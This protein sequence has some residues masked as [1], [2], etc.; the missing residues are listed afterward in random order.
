V[1]RS[2]NRLRIN[3]ITEE[4]G[5][6]FVAMLNAVTAPS[7][8]SISSVDKPGLPFLK[9]HRSMVGRCVELLRSA[10]VA[11]SVAVKRGEARGSVVGFLQQPCDRQEGEVRWQPRSVPE[12]RLRPEERNRGRQRSPRSV[13]CVTSHGDRHGLDCRLPVL[14]VARL[15][16]R[17]DGGLPMDLFFRLHGRTVLGGRLVRAGS[18]RRGRMPGPRAGR[19]PAARVAGRL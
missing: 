3:D 18:A 2:V 10:P 14:V 7:R 5:V 8:W 12:G 17:G 4:I 19:P 16:Q 6:D 1:S 15:A 9:D 11:V 13:R